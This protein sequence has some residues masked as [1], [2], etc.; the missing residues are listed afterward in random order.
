MD[1][2]DLLRYVIS[3][4]ESQ[5]LTYMLVGS[6]ASSIYGEPRFTHDI[7]IVVHLAPDAANRLCDAFPSPDF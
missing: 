6:Y 1:Q 3:V 5:Q 7:D 4:L 2:A